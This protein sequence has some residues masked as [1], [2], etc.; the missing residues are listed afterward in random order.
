[1]SSRSII[2]LFFTILWSIN[3]SNMKAYRLNNDKIQMNNLDES[4]ERKD[5]YIIQRLQALLAPIE[6]ADDG[7]NMKNYSPFDHII[8]T[9]LAVNRRPGLIRLKKK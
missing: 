1:M 3:I 2:V 5:P 4:V 8:S 6:V 9:R 7:S